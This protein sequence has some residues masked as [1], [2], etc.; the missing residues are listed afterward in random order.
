M[1]APRLSTE[2]F[3]VFHS[4]GWGDEGG[5]NRTALELAMIL[6]LNYGNSGKVKKKTSGVKYHNTYS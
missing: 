5:E 4:D 2:S 6:S 1:T 3:A